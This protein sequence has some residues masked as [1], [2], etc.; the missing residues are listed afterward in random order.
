LPLSAKIRRKFS[1]G[2]H[3]HCF[4][5]KTFGHLKKKTLSFG[6]PINA[7]WPIITPDAPPLLIKITFRG[8]ANPFIHTSIISFP[9]VF[10]LQE[11]PKA[12]ADKG[13]KPCEENS[14][15]PKRRTIRE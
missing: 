6:I 11:N 1:I 4:V 7:Y 10:F 9:L 15:P 2:N 5:E 14:P 3:E 13:K 8:S 12:M